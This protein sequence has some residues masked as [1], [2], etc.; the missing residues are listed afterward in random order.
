MI[1]VLNGTKEHHDRPPR[2]DWTPQISSNSEIGSQGFVQSHRKSNSLSSP[3]TQGS[4]S[5]LLPD[6]PAGDEVADQRR[7]SIGDKPP[8]RRTSEKKSSWWTHRKTSSDGGESSFFLD[9]D[10]AN[11]ISESKSEIFK[12]AFAMPQN[13]K[14]LQSKLRCLLTFLTTNLEI[15]SLLCF[16]YENI[17]SIGKAVCFHKL[18]LL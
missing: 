13:E 2:L 1:D 7:N 5:E 8:M 11:A 10:L 14:L 18:Y 3:V 15:F 17:A 6:K 9:E 4:T 16:L 12:S